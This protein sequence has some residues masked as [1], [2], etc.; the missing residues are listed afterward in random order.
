MLQK[1]AWMGNRGQDCQEIDNLY[2]LGKIKKVSP[3]FQVYM[4]LDSHGS[5][6]GNTKN[7]LINVFP[8]ILFKLEL[9]IKSTRV[10]RNHPKYPDIAPLS[11]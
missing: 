3:T 2:L 11:L 1:G 5:V 7:S 6:I 4:Y 10:A 8:V 9:I